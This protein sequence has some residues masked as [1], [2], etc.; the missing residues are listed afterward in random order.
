MRGFRVP[1]SSFFVLVPTYGS[2]HA[3]SCP[4]CPGHPPAQR[5]HILGRLGLQDLNK[6]GFGTLGPHFGGTLDVQG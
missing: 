1:D 3:G 5:P 2:S 4:P 6:Q